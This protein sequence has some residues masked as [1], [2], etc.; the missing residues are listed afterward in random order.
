MSACISTAVTAIQVRWHTYKQ[1]KSNPTPSATIQHILRAHYQANIWAQ[2]L[3]LEPTMLD[4]IGLG[5]HEDDVRTYIP[6][7]SGVIPEPTHKYGTD[8][9][10]SLLFF[11]VFVVVAT[12]NNFTRLYR[13]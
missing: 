5:W 3:V 4:P 6:T 13:N 2:D 1:L 9:D 11:V 12:L 7:L 8:Y 10:N